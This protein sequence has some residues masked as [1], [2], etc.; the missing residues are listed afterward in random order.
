MTNPSGQDGQLWG[1]PELAQAQAT[2][3]QPA[4]PAVA[5][6]SPPSLPADQS[7]KLRIVTVRMPDG[8]HSAI[9]NAAHD[10]RIS[11]NA[12]CVAALIAATGYRPSDHAAQAADA[13]Q[14]SQA[15]ERPRSQSSR[16]AA[17][18]A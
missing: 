1:S 5:P 10:A 16:M 11:A 7:A 12:Y 3:S 8:L 2:E 4:T 18:N 17:Q 13:S 14:A 9:T 15:A 6:T